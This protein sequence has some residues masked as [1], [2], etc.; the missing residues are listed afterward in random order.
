MII[1]ALKAFDIVYVMTS[2][3]FDTDV[4]ANRMYKEL[5][6]FGQPR[7]GQRGRDDPASC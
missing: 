3:N 4:I 5:F 1:T 2:G 7:P 6:N